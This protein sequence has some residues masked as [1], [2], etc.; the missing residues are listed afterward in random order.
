MIVERFSAGI[1]WYYEHFCNLAEF[2]ELQRGALLFVH[3]AGNTNLRNAFVA[4]ARVP[5]GEQSYG[6][7]IKVKN[8][9][10]L[11]PQL[12]S[13][14]SR[15]EQGNSPLGSHFTQRACWGFIHRH[16]RPRAHSCETHTHSSVRIGDCDVRIPKEL[17]EVGSW[18]LVGLKT[19][20]SYDPAKTSC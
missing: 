10:P 8:T 5:C 6:A 14:N 1:S 15:L 2:A 17:S 20:T 4:L 11:L 19:K 16:E 18:K 7:I 9:L 3:L 12:Q 13:A